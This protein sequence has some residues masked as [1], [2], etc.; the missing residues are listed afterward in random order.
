M[1][2]LDYRLR[3]FF[4]KPETKG[5][6]N[7]IHNERKGI[8]D[9]YRQCFQFYSIP[10]PQSVTSNQQYEHYCTYL[11]FLFLNRFNKLR[12]KGG[13]SKNACQNAYK[14]FIHISIILSRRICFYNL[15]FVLYVNFI[16][17]ISTIIYPVSIL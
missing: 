17:C 5:K 4:T 7:N 3:F 16:P 2:Y 14:F 10:N 13:C 6:H 1:Y 12:N 15:L 8:G 11:Y 9:N